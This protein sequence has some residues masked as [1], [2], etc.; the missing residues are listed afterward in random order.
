[1]QQALRDNGI[2]PGAQLVIAHRGSLFDCDIA[3]QPAEPGQQAW[4]RYV[5]VDDDGNLEYEEFDEPIRYALDT[6]V[7]VAAARWEDIDALFQ[8]AEEVGAGIFQ[9]MYEICCEWWE[10]GNREPLYVTADVLFEEIHY[11]HRLTSPVTIHWEL[12]KRLAFEPTGDDRY[13][14]RPEY[15]DHIRSIGEAVRLG[16]EG[17]RLIYEAPLG[18]ARQSAR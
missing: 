12:W 14:F 5:S 2:Y 3:T 13:R 17:P 9:F 10:E 7:F 1:M 6:S 15:G 16:L 8:E 11:N 18:L 4:V